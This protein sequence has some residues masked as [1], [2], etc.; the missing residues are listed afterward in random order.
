MTHE[1]EDKPWQVLSSEYLFREPWLTVRRD[2]LLLP[3]GNHIPAYYVMEYPDWV[4]VIAITREGQFVLVRQYRHARRVTAYELC[5]GVCEATDASPLD[6]ARRE[7]LEETGYGN[8]TWTLYMEVCGNPGKDS[9][10]TY[11]FLATD[12]E[13]VSGQH[14]DETESL[15]VHLLTY[16]EVKAL[17]QTNQVHQALMAAPLW[18]YVAEHR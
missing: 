6:A 16:E 18:K 5:A 15:T 12:V 17:L 13:K 7:L 9:N 11:C 1:P 10:K 8:G 4:N 3:N 2:H 14:L